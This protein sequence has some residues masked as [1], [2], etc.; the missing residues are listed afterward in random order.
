MIGAVTPYRSLVLHYVEV[1]DQ[2]VQ[3]MRKLMD[4]ERIALT[5][6][7]LSVLAK[8]ERARS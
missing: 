8:E 2:A 1:A 5:E 4:C 7:A 6:D 3:R